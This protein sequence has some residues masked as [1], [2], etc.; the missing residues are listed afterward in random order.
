MTEKPPHQPGLQDPP[1]ARGSGAVLSPLQSG[2]RVPF[3]LRV[4]NHAPDSHPLIHS[5]ISGM[6]VKD[7]RILISQAFFIASCQQRALF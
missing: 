4:S 2:A 3:P 5:S 6:H 1:L 7:D